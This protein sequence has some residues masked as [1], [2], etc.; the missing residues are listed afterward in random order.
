MTLHVSLQ[1]VYSNAHLCLLCGC[2]LVFNNAAA[3]IVLENLAK[4]PPFSPILFIVKSF[5]L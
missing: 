2:L 1:G 3:L 5:K 4:P